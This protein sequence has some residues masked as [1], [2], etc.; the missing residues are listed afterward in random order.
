MDRRGASSGTAPRPDC[1]D[2]AE[3]ATEQH[4]NRSIIIPRKWGDTRPRDFAGSARCM[5]CD[6]DAQAIYHV[7]D[8][9]CTGS[10]RRATVR[11]GEE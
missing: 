11:Y 3:N 1:S 8:F 7:I 4:D 10:V 5:C 6:A 9:D 2:G